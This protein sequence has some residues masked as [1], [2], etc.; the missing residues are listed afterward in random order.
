M[1][2]LV[3]NLMDGFGQGTIEIRTGSGI[4][5]KRGKG[6]SEAGFAGIAAEDFS[7]CLQDEECE[8]DLSTADVRLQSK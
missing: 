8:M 4:I 6:F 5:F 2:Q 7:C 1:R 3:M